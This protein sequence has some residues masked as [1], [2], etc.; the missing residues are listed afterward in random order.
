ME[1]QDVAR[2]SQARNDLLTL[3]TSYQSVLLLFRRCRYPSQKEWERKESLLLHVVSLLERGKHWE[4][5]VPVCKELANVYE[6]KVQEMR[7]HYKKLF[8]TVLICARSS[9]IAS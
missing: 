7:H 4:H 9:T 3:S 5:A 2:G 6:H 1:L 8:K